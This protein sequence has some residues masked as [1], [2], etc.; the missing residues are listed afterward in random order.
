MLVSDDMIQRSPENQLFALNAIDWLAQDDALMAIRA[1]N[2][3]PPPLVFPSEAVK[4]AVKYVNLIGLP[5][6]IALI[7]FGHL[8]RRRRRALV[9]YRP[10]EV[11][12]S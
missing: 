7:G 3:R 5:L 9:P 11:P 6:A 1:K 4:Q 12:A 10:Q 8:I 2:R